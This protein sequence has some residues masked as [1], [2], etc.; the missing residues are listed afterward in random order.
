MRVL[1][2]YLPT[3]I[4]YYFRGGSILLI[5]QILD[6]LLGFVSL[7]VFTSS[8]DK[9]TYGIYGYLL[10][11]FA[12]AALATSP[13]VETAIQYD[14]ARGND[15]G[16]A[17]GTRRRLRTAL[18]GSIGMVVWAALLYRRGDTR[19]ALAVL[20]GAP[21]LPF[22]YGMA[23]FKAYLMGKGA[24]GRLSVSSLLIEVGKLLF[25]LI[26][27][28]LF[29]GLPLVIGF[30]VTA[31]VLNSLFN[32]FYVRRAP[33]ANVGEEFDEIGNRLTLAAVVGSLAG[34]ADRLIVGTFFGLETMALYNMAVSVTRPLR[35]LG[36]VAAKLLFPKMINLNVTSTVFKR[37]L[38]FSLLFITVPLVALVVA[39]HLIFPALAA[40][41]FP[42]YGAAVPMV[43]LAIAATAMSIWGIIASQALWSFGDLRMI[44]L[45]Q[46]ISP[47]L[48]TLVVVLGAV[49]GGVT[50]I[51]WGRVA[52]RLLG[53]ALL[54]AVLLVLFRRTR[55]Q[56]EGAHVGQ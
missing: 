15:G 1:R 34:Q 30:F 25:I 46:T 7:Y 42:K 22:F 19:L 26:A 2:R 18:L 29:S 55:R 31:S 45:V 33:N 50:G 28:R 8:T 20:A 39:Y 49:W 27:C 51:L 37:K 23:G 54:V 24:F 11:V 9:G 38:V 52:S 3:D 56:G 13:G 35:N 5:N 44:Y 17:H 4:A 21:I 43:R 53:N 12:V 36:I 16:L 41:L 32:W 48:R 47:I 10:S 6:L 14:A 40:A